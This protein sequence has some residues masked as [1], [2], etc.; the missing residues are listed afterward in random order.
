[1]D[2]KKM[3]PRSDAFRWHSKQELCEYFNIRYG[4][5]RK[6]VESEIDEAIK[7][8]R[9]RKHLPIRMEELW[10]KVGLRMEKKLKSLDL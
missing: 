1:M 8:F 3:Q 9:L 7:S 4:L 2:E 10:Q 5:G 6:L